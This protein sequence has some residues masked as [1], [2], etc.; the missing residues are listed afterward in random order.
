MC[1]FARAGRGRVQKDNCP[2]S[3]WTQNLSAGFIFRNK[4][5]DPPRKETS[6]Y[7]ETLRLNKDRLPME[8]L[9]KEIGQSSL[10]GRM[11]GGAELDLFTTGSQAALVGA[12]V[13]TRS[14]APIL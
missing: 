3:M 13:C 2:Q 14:L 11:E 1:L 4:E 5:T 7:T 8:D 12:Q 10:H 9:L 6:P